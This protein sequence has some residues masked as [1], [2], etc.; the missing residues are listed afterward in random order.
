MFCTSA[1][2]CTKHTWSDQSYLTGLFLAT[3]LKPDSEGSLEG[4]AV[5][6]RT[7]RN[8][9]KVKDHNSTKQICLCVYLYTAT[10]ADL[11]PLRRMRRNPV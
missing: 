7:P 10:E 2:N 5:K 11:A 3:D 6:V 9:H 4:K 8:S 1:H